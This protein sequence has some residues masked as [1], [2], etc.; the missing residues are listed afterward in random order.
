[1]LYFVLKYSM[2][3]Y[4]FNSA[5]KL[6]LYFVFGRIKIFDLFYYSLSLFTCKVT[7]IYFQYYRIK[8][9]VNVNVN[10]ADIGGTLYL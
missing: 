5:T 7:Q 4:A 10:Q 8:Y 3:K 1:M 2:E 6:I 9:L